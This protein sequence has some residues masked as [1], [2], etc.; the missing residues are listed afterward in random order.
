[1]MNRP[2]RA[3]AIALSLWMA[4]PA[5]AVPSAVSPPVTFGPGG[6]ASYTD[7]RIVGAVQPGDS[8]ILTP[9]VNG[10]PALNG[11]GGNVQ[12]YVGNVP[13]NLSMSE[14]AMFL[15]GTVGHGSTV[16]CRGVLPAVLSV[17]CH[18]VATLNGTVTLGNGNGTALQ[19]VDPGGTVGDY[20]T[21]QP[22]TVSNAIAVFG[23]AGAYGTP[24]QIN[25]GAGA[26]VGIGIGSKGYGNGCVAIGY[27]AQCYGLGSNARGFG[28]YDIGYKQTDVWSSGNPTGASAYAN[29]VMQ[30]WIGSTTGATTARLSVDGVTTSHFSS[31]PV[32]PSGAASFDILLQAKNSAGTDVGTWFIKAALAQGASGNAVLAWK[33]GDGALPAAQTGPGTTLSGASA[34]LSVDT[35]NSGLNLTVTGVSG[36]NIVWSARVNWIMR[37]N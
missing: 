5:L 20:F 32:E 6:V 34:A 26:G 19:T 2:S 11:P 31:G 18:I 3:L 35:T 16:L 8:R 12:A 27:N 10:Y 25:G 28:T 4:G 21:L 7:S 23:L 13:A 29:A 37:T 17:S 15:G 1:M 9:D 22:G 14:F 30:T 36:V 24:M 33:T